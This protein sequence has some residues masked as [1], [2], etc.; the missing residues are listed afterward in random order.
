MRAALNGR[1]F[2][3]LP[4]PLVAGTNLENTRGGRFTSGASV[5]AVVALLDEASRLGPRTS[6][7]ADLW[8]VAPWASQSEALAVGAR[9]AIHAA[10]RCS[11][12]LTSSSSFDQSTTTCRLAGGFLIEIPPFGA[13]GL[14][15]FFVFFASSSRA[16]PFPRD[17]CRRLGG[18][19]TTS[20]DEDDELL[21]DGRMAGA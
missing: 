20:L 13:G 9:A 1:D 6:P 21:S 15:G 16:G 2:L 8:P 7:R 18:F 19:S 5:L 4:C 10:R 17:G 11:I 12:L 14:F 3:E